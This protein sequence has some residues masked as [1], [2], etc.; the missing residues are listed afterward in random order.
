MTMKVPL[1]E[2]EKG[3]ALRSDSVCKELKLDFAVCSECPQG[4]VKYKLGA[5]V[6]IATARHLLATE[7]SLPVN[8]DVLKGAGL[9]LGQD[10]LY[11]I[12]RAAPRGF[13]VGT[14][15]ATL[16]KKMLVLVDKFA[17][18][19]GDKKAKRLFDA[20]LGKQSTVN[21][22]TDA[23]LDKA[24]EAHKNFIRF[25]ELTVAAPGT[26]GTTPGRVRVHQA[27]KN[28]GWDIHR[29][30]LLTDLGP[31]A[32]NLGDK[33]R[34]TE[35]FDN[36]LGVMMNG[37]QHVFVYAQ[38]YEY[39]S[40]KQEYKLKLKF[41]MYDVFGLDDGDLT[42]PQAWGLTTTGAAN[43]WLATSAQQGITA[44]WQLQHQFDYA[45]LLV[46]AV[47]EKTFVVS[48]KEPPP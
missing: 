28:E 6:L 20:F 19:D 25:S 12:G 38:E 31:P 45:P 41:V 22:F 32:F 21:V 33:A 37:V 30:E 15:E 43:S 4:C 26:A 9:E 27:L 14:D 34:S 36:G 13:S 1:A 17:S 18:G 42:D 47:V 40:C 7:V 10:V 29:V 46:R 24:V 35:D 8:D 5:P 44:W 2:L 16:K 11:S 3:V 48:T 23:T 39:D